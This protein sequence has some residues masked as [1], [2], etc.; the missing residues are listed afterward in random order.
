MWLFFVLVFIEKVPLSL[1]TEDIYGNSQKS[2][3][4]ATKSTKT[5][6]F[7]IG[8]FVFQVVLWI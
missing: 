1:V 8:P 5:L 2:I 6:F 4:I 3:D 7:S